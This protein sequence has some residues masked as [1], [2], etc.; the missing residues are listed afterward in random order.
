MVICKTCKKFAKIHS[1]EMNKFTGE[2]RNFM[3]ECK[4]HGVTEGNFDDWEEL[5]FDTENYGKQ[6]D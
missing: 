6:I 4:A 2:W 1:I 3:V 5:N